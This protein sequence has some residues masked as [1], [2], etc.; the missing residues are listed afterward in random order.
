MVVKIIA[1][2]LTS[3][4]SM[5]APGIP[6]ANARFL[7]ASLLWDEIDAARQVGKLCPGGNSYT[8]SQL[9]CARPKQNS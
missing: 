5:A 1:F 3:T 4:G 9:F 8:R 2:I 6:A 7:F